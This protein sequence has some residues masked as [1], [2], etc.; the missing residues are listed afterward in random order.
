VTELLDEAADIFEEQSMLFSAERAWEEL[1]AMP[2]EVAALD[3]SLTDEER[4][5]RF[6]CGGRGHADWS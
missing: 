3:G 1:A 2:P 6:G 4:R 5:A